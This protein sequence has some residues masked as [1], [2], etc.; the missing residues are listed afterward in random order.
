MQLIIQDLPQDHL[1]HKAHLANIIVLMIK[2]MIYTI[3]PHLL[4]L[5]LE[6]LLMTQ[7]KKSETNI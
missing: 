3:I 7:V 2:L 4:N 1:E 6:E 5:E